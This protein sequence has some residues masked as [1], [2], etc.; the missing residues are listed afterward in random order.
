VTGARDRRLRG[1]RGK[2]RISSR[3]VT[4]QLSVRYELA[5]RAELAMSQPHD[6][7]EP[8][9]F[10]ESE[11][12]LDYCLIDEHHRMLQQRDRALGTARGAG[13]CSY[14]LSSETT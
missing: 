11:L 5:T 8:H 12:F 1:L 9:D 13:C 14:C 6:F 4:R 3:T 10:T 7:N 2:L